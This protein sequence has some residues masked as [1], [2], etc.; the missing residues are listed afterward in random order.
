MTPSLLS[1]PLQQSSTIHSPETTSTGSSDVSP[2]ALKDL[3][4]EDLKCVFRERIDT[5]RARYLPN[6]RRRIVMIA[7]TS[8]E[9]VAAATLVLWL[10]A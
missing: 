2:E 7:R 6:S 3:L 5:H 9:K 4:Q 8:R 1:P 10:P